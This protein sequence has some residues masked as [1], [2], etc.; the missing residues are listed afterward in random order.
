MMVGQAALVGGASLHCSSAPGHH[1]A[2]VP[3]SPPSG[4]SSRASSGRQGIQASTTTSASPRRTAS[5][6]PRGPQPRHHPSTARA[7][8]SPPTTPAYTPEITPSKVGKGARAIDELATVIEVSPRD[9]RRFKRPAGGEQELREPA[10]PHLP[11]GGGGRG[12]AGI[13]GASWLRDQGAAVPSPTCTARLRTPSATSAHQ[14]G[15]RAPHRVGG[16]HDQPQGHRPHRQARHRGATRRSCTATRAASR[17]R[18]TPAGAPSARFPARS[19]SRATTWSPPSTSSCRRWPRRPSRTT[20]ALVALDPATGDVLALVSKPGFDPNLFVDGI[21]PVNWDKPTTRPTSRS[22]TGR[23]A[24][25]VPPGLD[26]Q[27]VHGA[28]GAALRQAHA[29]AVDLGPRPLD[30]AGVLRPFP[31]LEVGGSMGVVNLRL[32]VVSSTPTAIRTTSAS[33]RSTAS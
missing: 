32:P 29:R 13:A 18:S 9:R 33:T 21:D 26:H 7:R 25:A 14:R 23:C 15:R 24:A 28:R 6:R 8:C 10:D 11:H 31:R 30:A 19:R 5:G 20:A 16:P 17:W 2:G 4:S 3:R 27:A 22:T 12:F 1:Q